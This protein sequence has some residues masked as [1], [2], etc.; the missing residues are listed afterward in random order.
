MIVFG[1]GCF[2][3]SAVNAFIERFN[4]DTLVLVMIHYFTSIILSTDKVSQTT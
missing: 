4:P 2:Q 3:F 1:S